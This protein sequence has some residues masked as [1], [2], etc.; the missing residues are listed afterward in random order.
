MRMFA[1]KIRAIDPETGEMETWEGPH[2]PGISIADAKD[3]CQ[4]HGLGYCE[5][6]GEL[7]ATVPIKPG[8]TEPDMSKIVDYR[9]LN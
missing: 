7:V 2:V 4:N 6:Y 8:T 9:N 3:Y 1:T 5:V